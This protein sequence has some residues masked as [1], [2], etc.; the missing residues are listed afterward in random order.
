MELYDGGAFEGFTAILKNADQ[1]RQKKRE[2]RREKGCLRK[3]KGRLSTSP[4]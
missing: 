1:K 2:N 4:E 3:L